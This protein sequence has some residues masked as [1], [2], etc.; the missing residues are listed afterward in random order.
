M[1]NFLPCTGTIRRFSTIH[2]TTSSVVPHVRY[3]TGVETGSEISVYFD[4]MIAKIVV[5]GLDRASA[6]RLAKRVLAATTILGLGTNQEFLGRCLA[7]P[8]FQ[9]KNYTTGFIEQYRQELFRSVESESERIAVLTSGFLK[10]IAEEDRRRNGAFRSISSKFRVQSMDR[11]SVKAEQITVGGKGYIVQYLPRR[12][13]AAD[14]VQVW[15]ISEQKLEEKQKDKFLNKAGGVLVHRYYTALTHPAN[16]R[17]MDISIIHASLR[18]QGRLPDQWIEGDVTVQLD[19][20]VKTI[21]VAT[22][23][24]WRAR[25]DSAQTVWIHAPELCAGIKSIRRSLLTFAGRLDERTTGSAAEL[26][27]VSGFRN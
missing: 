15:E 18:P 26:G 23:G 2:E 27:S 5:W 7:H 12:G 21:F 13:E 14:T 6:I 9:D 24:D 16:P 11:S 20:T 25:D 17:T 10:Y 8:G 19:G 4:P 22:E 1:N 3:E